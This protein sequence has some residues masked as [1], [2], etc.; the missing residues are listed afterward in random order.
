MLIPSG[1]DL[2][3]SELPNSKNFNAS[4]S[5]PD[6]NLYKLYF[7]RPGQNQTAGMDGQIST[8]PPEAD[9]DQEVASA[10][11][12]DV[13][14]M[15]IS[16]M[17]SM[18]FFGRKF[19]ANDTYYIP[20]ELFLK[21]EGSQN[22]NVDWTVTVMTSDGTV[23]S[24]TYPGSV[25]SSSFGSSCDFDH[26]IIE[27][28]IGNSES[29]QVRKNERLII[30]VRASMSG[31]D[32]SDSP[33]GGSCTADVAFNN[34]DN[35]PNKFSKMEAN[36]NALMNSIIVVQR[37]GAN[38]AE[39]S[40]I[41]W[42]PND[43][44]E[45]REMQFS[46]DA[47]SAFGRADIARVDILMRGPD[48]NYEIDERI[49]GDTEGIEDSST[50][51]FGKFLY[52]Y[53]SGLSSGEYAVILKVRDVGGNE[54]EIEH[55]PIEMH[56]FGV[57]LKHRFDRSIEYFAPGKVTPIPMVLIHR[58][59]STKSINV[60]LEVLTNLGS[61]WLV[62]FDSPAGYEMSSGGAVMNPTVTLTA[63][64]DLTG[65]PKKIEIRAVA[66]ADVDGV[67]SVVHQD[68]LVLVVEKIDVY[69]PP[70]VSIWSE[71]HKMPIANSSRGDA[72]D[73]TI[74]RFAEYGEFNPFILEIFNTGFDADTFRIDILKRSKSIFQLHDNLTGQR[75]LQDEGD[76]TFHTPLLERHSTKILILG[77]KPSLDR[78]D[79]DIGEIEIEV[80]SGGNA[81]TT[82]TVSFTIQ[83]TYGI[84]GEVSQDCD[85][86]PLGHM[87]VA[88]CAPG[89]D[90]PILDFR[91][92]L[93]NSE[94]DLEAASWWLLQNP[95]SLNENTDRNSA[96]GQWEFRITNSDGE[97]TPRVSL[98]PGDFTEVYIS[99]TLTN[100]VEVG[101]H[102]VFLRIIE[103]IEDDDPRYFD[104]PMTF[105]IEADQP[106]LEIVQVSQNM[107][108]A[109]GNDYTIN[110]KVKN[111]GNSPM[112]V[113][114][115]A[116]VDESGWDVSIGGLSGSPL[117]EIEA[118]DEATF[119]VEISVSSSANNGDS[120]PISVTA[121]PLDT[122]QSFSE[123]LTA[124]FTLT[125]IVEIG[126]F[127]DIIVNEMS[128][129][130]PITLVLVLVSV[131]LLF[132][133]V[134]S[135]LNRRRWAAQMRAIESLSE[136][137]TESQ[138]TTPQIP[139]PVTVV[140]EPKGVERYDDDDVELM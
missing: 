54:I 97:A 68:T 79:E 108:L 60:E 7:V 100:Q 85:G 3:A 117:I 80:I 9:E 61:S 8:E 63:P 78:D 35:E 86:T 123:S 122:D 13:Q 10:L 126:S 66:E 18:E 113:L 135:R 139:A 15:S 28:G 104:L 16:L 48:G 110:M 53:N 42:Y 120:I 114:L 36:G 131:L 111:E 25:C 45:D 137:E 109:P 20:V 136:N 19:H 115:E 39:G 26:E 116:E 46:I 129:P 24:T 38:I 1:F 105:E 124:K 133:G 47:I 112:T 43:I 64:D 77:V 130:R 82:T 94:T 88:L 70:V 75:I 62:E 96:Y 101:N 102:T 91:A 119:T 67:I 65:M 40:E 92:R 134:Q 87:K 127:V 51:I 138:E 140:E 44:V 76:G 11:D 52:T 83:R 41:D 103:D 31:C 59:D 81:S 29:F 27:V 33:F 72:L 55:E 73:S 22:S 49:T 90:R 74:P 95:A 107:K 99:V 132:A 128:H 37:E 34:I 2:E 32:S 125:V 56:Q 106:M 5:A 69:Q 6:A 121:T 84:R 57:S 58:G 93:T 4:E 17:S 89:Q 21:S 14:F 71:D 50:G 118:F 12:D 23:G 30:K 98:G